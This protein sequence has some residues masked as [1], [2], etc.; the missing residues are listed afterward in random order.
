[1][2][3]TEDMLGISSKKPTSKWELPA[4]KEKKKPHNKN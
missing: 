1:M 2:Q 3:M 4:L